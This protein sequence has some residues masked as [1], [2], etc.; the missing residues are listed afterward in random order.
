MRSRIP[1]ATPFPRRDRASRIG[2]MTAPQVTRGLHSVR[3]VALAFGAGVASFAVVSL[4]VVAI[5]PDVLVACLGVA[6]L[7]AFAAV[8]RRWGVAYAVP[9]AMAGLV[10]YDWFQFPP[11]HPREFPSAGDLANLGAYLAAAVLFGQLPSYA[12]RR[13]DVSEA[14]RGKLA[15]EQAALRRVATLVAHGVPA[16][17]LFAAVAAEAGELLDVDATHIG[18]YEADGRVV[19]AGSWSRHGDHLPPGTRVERDDDSVTWTV[20]RTGRP[21]RADDYSAATG[22]VP[23]LLR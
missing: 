10:A 6:Y 17:E 2:A 5:G 20:Q 14:A 12:R 18:R 15:D 9:V 3:E 19:G 13:A 11:T 4:T 21:A 23:T 16:E 8:F 7:V 22:A 1:W